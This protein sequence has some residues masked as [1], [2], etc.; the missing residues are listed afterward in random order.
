ME[1]FLVKDYPGAVSDINAVCRCCL[2]SEKLQKIFVNG[3]ELNSEVE[4][5]LR[6]AYIP[7]SPNDGLPNLICA[8]CVEELRNWHR[9]RQ[10]C[11]ESYKLLERLQECSIDVLEE[12][13]KVFVEST[14]LVTISDTV[15]IE[16]Q[17]I[18]VQDEPVNVFK[19]EPEVFIQDDPDPDELKEDHQD[20]GTANQESSTTCVNIKVEPVSCAETFYRAKLVE[21]QVLGG[22]KKRYIYHRQCPICGIVLKRGL[23]EHIMIHNDPT[24]R[25]FKCDSCHKTYCRKDNLR[26]HQEREHLLIRYHCD[27]CGKIFSTRDVLNAHRKLHNTESFKCD[28]CDQVFKTT[29]YLYK[30]KQK[31]LGIKK[32]ICTYCGKG[33]LVGEYLKDHLRIHTGEKPFDCK[34]CGKLFRTTNHLRQHTRTHS[35][36]VISDQKSPSDGDISRNENSVLPD[37]M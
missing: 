12:A 10:K 30:H 36:P 5:L 8:S 3:E 25:P 33:F 27:I 11:D 20:T 15:G 1:T 9:F 24:G 4:E 13:E 22:K 35:I 31:H 7:L 2:A 19:Q 17:E 34:I 14:A 29:K 21:K 6:P 26:Q 37:S 16:E 28:Q 18:F 32:F 23:R